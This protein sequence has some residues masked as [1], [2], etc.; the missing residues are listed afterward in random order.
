[1]INLATKNVVFRHWFQMIFLWP[2]FTVQIKKMFDLD[3]IQSSIRSSVASADPSWFS[4]FDDESF[5]SFHFLF[6]K[7][8][9]L[10]I[11]RPFLDEESEA[12]GMFLL[13]DF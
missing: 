10:N 5:L 2:R 12:Q 8:Q 7:P 9:I 1:M 6:T 3:E 11:K 13:F 4:L